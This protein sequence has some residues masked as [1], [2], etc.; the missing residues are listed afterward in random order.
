MSA[1]A[2]IGGYGADLALGDPVR[3]HPVAGFGRLAARLERAVWAPS[4]A[5]GIGFALGLVGATA[6]AAEGLA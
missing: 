1:L 5:R 4:R 2:L 3:W 6:L